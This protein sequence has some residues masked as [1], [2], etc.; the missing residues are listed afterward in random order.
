VNKEKSIVIVENHTIVREGLRL[1]LSSHG[2]FQVVGEAEDGIGA[3]RCAQELQPDLILMDIS[4]P[5]MNGME[6]I[7]EVKKQSP[8]TRILILT[9]HKTEEYVHASLKAGADGYISKDANHNELLMAIENV[10][11]GKRYLSPEISNKVI[12]GYL[13]GRKGLEQDFKWNS[14][15]TRERAVLKLVAEGLRNKEIADLLCISLN[16]VEKHRD[17]LMKKLDLH[18]ASSLTLYAQEKGLLSE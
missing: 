9:V 4:M 15:T 13:E 14:L 16:T 5:R 7:G 12:N 1:L 10:L 11:C 18:N 2:K 6:A 3:I 8:N 17:N